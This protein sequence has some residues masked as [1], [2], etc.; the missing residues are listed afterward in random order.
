MKTIDPDQKVADLVKQYPQTWEV[1]KSYECPDMRRGFFSLM[2][3]IM[4]IRKAAFIHRI[5]LD[6][7]IA[8]LEAVI[9][10]NRQQKN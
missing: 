5:P 6:E 10:E 2:A 4:S 9:S 1:F 8:D 7:L 3:R